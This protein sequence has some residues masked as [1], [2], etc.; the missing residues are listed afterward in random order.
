[1]NELEDPNRQHNSPRTVCISSDVNGG[2]KSSPTSVRTSG[3]IASEEL[4]NRN[5]TEPQRAT[6][7]SSSP[8]VA[9]SGNNIVPEILKRDDNGQTPLHRAAESGDSELVS[10]LLTCGAEKEPRDYNRRIPL[11]LA[12]SSGDLDAVIALLG[13]GNDTRD[14]YG[15]TPMHIA[16]SKGNSEV[17]ELLVN[18]GA[19]NEA[20]DNSEQNP[21]HVAAKLGQT[22]VVRVL[23]HKGANKGAKDMNDRTPLHL[24]LNRTTALIL[25]DPNTFTVS[26]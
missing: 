12:A 2:N 7:R 18:E 25:L 4:E 21:L 14:K 13:P 1:M 10:L 24:V 20:Q 22:D 8:H 9:A 5:I 26:S 23:V 16:A 11:H 15:Q 3:I 6:L 17:V 19:N